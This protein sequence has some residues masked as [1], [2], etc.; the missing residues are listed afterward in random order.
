MMTSRSLKS[1]YKQSKKKHHSSHLQLIILKFIDKRW[2]AYHLSQLIILSS[3]LYDNQ[4][5]F[6]TLVL[7]VIGRLNQPI[8][9]HIF[10]DFQ[11]VFL[12]LEVVGRFNQP[13]VYKE[14]LTNQCYVPDAGRS[15]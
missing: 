9:N 8:I 4:S 2:L 13:I 11:P 5:V 7:Q 1:S 14:S 15:L 6:L 3:I 10:H 12:F